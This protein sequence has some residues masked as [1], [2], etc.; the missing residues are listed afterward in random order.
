M[1]LSTDGGRA[2]SLEVAVG[3]TQIRQNGRGGTELAA[4]EAGERHRE[5]HAGK[6]LAHVKRVV[7]WGVLTVRGQRLGV[8]IFHITPCK[9]FCNDALINLLYMYSKR[10]LVIT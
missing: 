9:V 7:K 1:E 8:Y 3:Q 10:F 6:G 5:G 4:G 2:D